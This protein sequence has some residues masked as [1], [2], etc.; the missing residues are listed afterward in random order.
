MHGGR[1]RF[2]QIG[3]VGLVPAAWVRYNPGMSD[4]SMPP[5]GSS[6]TTTHEVTESDTAEALGSGDLPVLATPRLLAWAEG[7]TCRAAAPGLDATRTSVGTLV[8]V[9]HRRPSRV[10]A[11]VSVRAELTGVDGRMLTFDVRAEDEERNEL[12]RG[13]VT[14]AVVD[15]ERFLGSLA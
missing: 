4:V 2:S 3:V 6:A 9:E 13:E 8:R 1:P 5:A 7:A 15:R 14:R 10:G 11:R 12:A